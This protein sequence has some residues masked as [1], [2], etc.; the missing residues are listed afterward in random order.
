MCALEWRG[1]LKRKRV[2]SESQEAKVTRT[3]GAKA[4][5]GGGQGSQG[6]AKAAK[7]A[8]VK[9]QEVQGGGCKKR[10]LGHELMLVPRHSKE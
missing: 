4:E 9:T 2:E 7:E 3:Q 5:A 10:G 1:F 8:A 6:L